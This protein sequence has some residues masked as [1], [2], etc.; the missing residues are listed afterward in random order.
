MNYKFDL[1]KGLLQ[2]YYGDKNISKEEIDLIWN[3]VIYM[4]ISYMK[5]YGDDAVESLWEILKFG[6]KQKNEFFHSL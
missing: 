2:R 3:G 5:C 1:A 6:I 4:H